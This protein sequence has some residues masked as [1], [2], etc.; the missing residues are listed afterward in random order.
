MNTDRWRFYAEMIGIFAVVASLLALVV[1]L[2]QTQQVV[3]A[4]TYQARALDAMAGNALLME[5]E[6]ITLIL[7]RVDMSDPKTIEALDDIERRRLRSFFRIMRLDADNEYYQYQQG[8]LDEEYFEYNLKP[9]IKRTAP[10]WR[11]LGIAERRPSFHAFVESVL[12][13]E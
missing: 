11:A 13:E 9:R 4:S 1:E 7:A 12:A 8:Y 3:V 2:R 10:H 5:S 6:V